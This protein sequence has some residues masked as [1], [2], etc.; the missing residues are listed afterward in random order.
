M[1]SQLSEL[2]NL[3]DMTLEKDC[4]CEH[5]PTT[6]QKLTG[7]SCHSQKSVKASCRQSWAA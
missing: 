3:T 1:M 2:Y 5:L 7:R 6:L 4:G